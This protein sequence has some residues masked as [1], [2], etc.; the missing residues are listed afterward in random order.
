MPIKLKLLPYNYYYS[1]NVI[2]ILKCS[3]LSMHLSTLFD[4]TIKMITI[5]YYKYFY[6][7]FYLIVIFTDI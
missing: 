3:L 4:V 1:R 5:K 6:F 2:H 7:L